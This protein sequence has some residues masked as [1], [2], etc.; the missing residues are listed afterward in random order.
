MS[1]PA[2]IYYGT[3]SEKAFLDQM[4]EGPKAVLLLSNY[5]ASADKRTVWNGIDKAEVVEYARVLH[6]NAIARAGTMQR[7]ARSA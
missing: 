1:A 3:Q 4:A 5:I 7:L 6:G 2:E